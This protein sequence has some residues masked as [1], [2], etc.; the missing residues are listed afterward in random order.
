M[1]KATNVVNWGERAVEI[2]VIVLIAGYVMWHIFKFFT[3]I[4]RDV[5]K[6]CPK[7]QKSGTL[8]KVD[9]ILRNKRRTSSLEDRHGPGINEFRRVTVYKTTEY[10]VAT[11]RCNSCNHNFSYEHKS[12]YNS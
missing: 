12:S 6:K 5:A 10:W 1:P 3:W 11:Y 2:L 7:C 4:Q 9:D 8:E